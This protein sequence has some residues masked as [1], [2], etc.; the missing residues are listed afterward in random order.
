LQLAVEAVDL[1]FNVEEPRL[2]TGKE[3][4]ALGANFGMNDL[5]GRAGCPGV[6]AGANYGSVCVERGM[7]TVFHQNFLSFTPLHP[8]VTVRTHAAGG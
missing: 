4:V 2:L 3:W 1:A 8:F 6:P 7:N 5:F